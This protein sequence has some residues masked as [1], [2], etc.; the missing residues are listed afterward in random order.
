MKKI[1]TIAR[2]IAIALCAVLAAALLCGCVTVDFSSLARGGLT[3]S[4]SRETYSF[5]VGQVTD[6]KVELYCNVEYYSAPSDT[7]TLEIQPNLREYVSVEESGGVLTV[8]TTRKINWTGKAPVLTVGSSVLSSVTITGAGDFTAHDTIKADSF[9]LRMDGAGTGVAE[10]DVGNLS[11]NLAG[12]GS[13]TLSG[14]ADS[15]DFVLAGAGDV[16]ALPLQTRDAVINLSGVGTVR[17]SCSDSLNISAGGLGTVEYI[18]SP[19]INM[20]RGG[21][22][23]ISKVG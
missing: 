2:L 15:A 4:G 7:V 22:V 16:E 10:V 5:S 9:K 23:S 3:G 19:S 1:I 8:R 12:A 14:K 20:N 18:G 13:F 21:L 6:I 17:L 11:V